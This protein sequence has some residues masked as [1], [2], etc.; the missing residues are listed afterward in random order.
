MEKYEI[1]DTL[2]ERI[3][4]LLPRMKKRK[5]HAGRNVA[6][7][8]YQILE[9]LFWLLKT[10]SQWSALPS[11]F[12]PRSTVHDRYKLLVHE[13]FF[14]CLVSEL[15]EELEHLG[16]FD[17]S[18]GAV[19]GTF[20]TAKRGGQE[21]GKTKRGKGSKIMVITEKNGLPIAT[22]V[23]SA[24]PHEVTLLED[25]IDQAVT[26]VV[27]DYLIGDGA[28]D[29]DPLDTTLRNE[30]GIELIAPH[31]SNR[32]APKTQDGRKLRRYKRRWKVERVNAWLQ[33][34]RRV[35]IR[36]ERNVHHYLAFLL[37]AIADLL[38][39]RLDS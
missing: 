39:R 24:S 9:A 32:V 14:E 29:S 10:G 4:P 8:W 21:V 33:N 1:P 35:L 27:P 34:Y 28:Y 20:V 7:T 19:D 16:I 2:W 5:G 6:W 23:S 15:G 26:S 30:R 37:F 18:E 3:S 25:V 38:A 31:R 12:P 11:C 13:G 17:L 22:M 36:W